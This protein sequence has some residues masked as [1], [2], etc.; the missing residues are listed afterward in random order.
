MPL[1]VEKVRTP[2]LPIDDGRRTAGAHARERGFTLLELLVAV[3]IAALLAGVALPASWRYLDG[4]RY[5]ELLID[6]EQALHGARYTAVTG[7]QAV[8]VVLDAADRRFGVVSAAADDVENFLQ[9]I[10][11]DVLVSAET[12]AEVSRSGLAVI[13][14]YP[15][16]GSSG[17][18]INV[19][20]RSD[21]GT[22]EGG[23]RFSVNWLLA[24][25]D[26]TAL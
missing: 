23:M 4:M 5:R 25:V 14:F 2:T 8:D 15:N 3:G 21:T 24:R 19:R 6:V 1:P 7:G 20:R 13:R 10:P 16:G 22:A 17:G 26:K 11:D 12:A 18:S 9:P